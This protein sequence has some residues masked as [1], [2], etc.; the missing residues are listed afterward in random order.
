MLLKNIDGTYE[1]NCKGGK[2]DG[3][4]IAK[5]E[6]TY[7]GQFKKGLPHGVGTYV[8]SDGRIYEGEFVKGMK[9]GQGKLIVKEDSI[10]TGFWKKDV[11]VGQYEKPYKKVSKSPNVSGYTLN[12]VQDDINNL[13]FYIKINQKPEKYPRLN[14]IVQSGSYQTQIDANDFV[15]LTNVTFPIKLK[16]RYNQDFIE[17]EIYQPGLWEIKTDITYIKGLN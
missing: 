6:D 7:Q 16:A 4:G 11:Y 17:I 13:R 5:G 10:V 12:K 15:E 3:D 1:G 9:E 8:W 2:A 14:F